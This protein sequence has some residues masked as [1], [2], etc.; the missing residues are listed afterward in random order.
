MSRL[1]ESA[2]FLTMTSFWALNYVLLKIALQYEDPLFILSFRIG[3]AG[4]ISVLAFGRFFRMPKGMAVNGKIFI[5]SML[6]IGIFMTLWFTA[7][8]T[9]SAGLT[10][11]LVYTYPLFTVLFS[12]VFLRE[13]LNVRILA[14]LITGF[15]GVIVTFSGS[16][17]TGDIFGITLLMLAAISWA[18]GT[19]FYK[20]YLT[21]E[22][23]WS[24]N[25]LQYVYSFPVILLSAI[26]TEKFS[27]S[28]LTNVNFILIAIYMGSLGTTVAYFIYLYLFRHYKASSISSF[29]FLV[30]AI[31]IIFGYLILQKG[32]SIIVLIGFLIISVGIYLGAG[33]VQTESDTRQINRY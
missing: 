8:Q 22:N 18:T 11:I 9:V 21:S 6:N 19:V 28:G 31:S 27:Y 3:I 32:E 14:G 15:V 20:K 1:G 30:P 24:V 5:F 16:L 12:A 13:K 7:E 29:F 10:A 4:I 33:S 26:F 23:S 25:V 17:I 2:L